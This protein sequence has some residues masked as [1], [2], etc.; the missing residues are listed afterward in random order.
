MNEAVA[1]EKIPLITVLHFILANLINFVKK[2][3]VNVNVTTLF[4]QLPVTSIQQIF[5]V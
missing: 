5:G 4:V 1:Y 3:N 2:H